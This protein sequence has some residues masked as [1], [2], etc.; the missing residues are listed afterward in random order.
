M[1][2]TIR[3]FLVLSLFLAAT[4]F[5]GAEPSKDRRP[6]RTQLAAIASW[7][8]S[9]ANLPYADELPR[10]ELVPASELQRLRHKGP[11]LAQLRTASGEDPPQAIGGEHSTPLPQF[12]REVV[13]VYDDSTATIYLSESWNSASVAAQSVLVHE[14]VHH[15]QNRAGLKYACAGAREKPAYLAQKQWLETRGLNL[16]VEFQVDMFTVV[17]MSACME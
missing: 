14:M 3:L 9:H 2:R 1:L 7:V 13:A 16:E 4:G 12:R 5:A 10:V 15:L 8:S 17:G 6:T 11:L